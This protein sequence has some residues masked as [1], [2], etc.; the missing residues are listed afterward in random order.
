M[1]DDPTIRIGDW[2]R[3]PTWDVGYAAEVLAVVEQPC[4]TCVMLEV[5]TRRARGVDNDAHR[6]ASLRLASG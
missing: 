5:D 4:G 3:H 1:D 6:K 2:V